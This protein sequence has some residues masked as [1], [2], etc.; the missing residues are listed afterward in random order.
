MQGLDDHAHVPTLKLLPKD[1]PVVGSASACKVAALLGFKNVY[2]LDHGQSI[3][4]CNGRLRVQATA[5]ASVCPFRRG[6]TAFLHRSVS[7]L[8]MLF[9]LLFMPEPVCPGGFCWQA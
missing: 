5:G 9:I 1:K 6:S 7:V 8:P 4:L 2:E 3:D